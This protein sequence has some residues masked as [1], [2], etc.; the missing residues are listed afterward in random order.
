VEKTNTWSLSVFFL[1]VC[2]SCTSSDQGVTYDFEKIPERI[3]IG[4]DFWAVPMEDWQV[5][6][7]RIETVSKMQNALVSLLPYVLTAGDKPFRVSV[8]MGLLQSSG[9]HGAAGLTVGAEASE[10]EDV[11]AAVYFGKGL[12]LGVSSKGYMFLGLKTK[13][14]P[15]DFDMTMFQIDLEGNASA[16]GYTLLMTI[17]D[18]ENNPVASIT[19]QSEGEL[20]GTIKLVN[21]LKTSESKNN[22]PTFW[23]DDLTVEGPKFI[24]QP[25][26][27]F[28]PVLWTMYTLSR[29]TLKLTAQL[30]PLGTG[31]NHEAV[32]QVKEG[33]GWKALQ[34]VTMDP[35]ARTATWKVTE[36]DHTVSKE[37][38]ILFNYIN[39]S[40]K[41]G[42]AE[43]TGEIRNEPIGKVLRVGALTCQYH[44][45]F[46][47]SPLVKN[48]SASKPDL[49]YFSGD[50]IYEQNGGYPIKRYPEDIAILNYLGKWYMFGWA[51]GDLLRNTPAIC[52]PDDHDVFHGNLWGEEG[53]L[54][55]DQQ[56]SIKE[57]ITIGGTNQGFAQTVKFV[58]VVN[59]TQCAHLPDPYDPAPIDQGMSVWYTSLNYA[60]ISFAIVSDRIFKSGPT[61]VATWK[62]RP[63]HLLEPL[64]DPG[65]IDKPE[66]EFLGKRQEKFLKEWICDWNNAYMKVLLSQTLFAN[67][68]T[69]HG[70]FDGYLYGDLDSGG[71]PKSARDR[72][73]SI[74]RKGF[75]FH[76]AGDQHVPS[77][78]HYGINKFR[79]AG[80]C[81][82]TPAIAVGYSR[83]FRPDE[84]GIPVIN[85]PEHAYP[86][87]G[88]YRDAFGN[89]NYVYAI[90][91]PANFN[92]VGDRYE[93]ADIKSSGYG[94]V[95]FD[96]SQ[97]TITM[98]SWRFLADLTNPEKKDQHPG[99]PMT[100]SQFDNYGREAAAWL[101]ELKINGDPD[102]V[103]EVINSKT[104]ELEYSVRIK[105]N[106]YDPKVFS[107]DIFNIRVGYPEKNVW[108][109][110]DNLKPF[111][112]KGQ[113]EVQ[114]N[115]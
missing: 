15:G 101:P 43:Y 17:L 7:G 38:R 64:N 27:C 67:V 100:I 66:L 29:N 36:W 5:K 83:W 62:T 61:R 115:F 111:G 87:T 21:N 60:G 46:P 18:R 92:P 24:N 89:P 50:Q 31:E 106:K 95:I 22:G 88:E 91:N 109:L 32:L 78:V 20:S 10:E 113:K 13:A 4:E 108:K 68:A 98:E 71:W 96:R 58:N 99:W 57:G 97:R 6:N 79:D 75:V 104:G 40:G 51:F 35:D 12:D 2:F 45:G 69:H 107:N 1:L 73:V 52:T 34:T 80:W 26:N 76:I 77:L 41:T 49:L 53:M 103:V 81:Y 70:S 105:G 94:M 19:G 110:I 8:K 85:R 33:K 72:A 59:R 44:Y 102:P 11:R 39:A 48:L 65:M 114:I 86:N 93:L 3:W 54:A 56:Q 55:A 25:E 47:Y 112:S 9:N 28:G 16:G 42:N 30:P 74:L 82:V 37:Y 90:G 23:F 14:L 63:D 84:M